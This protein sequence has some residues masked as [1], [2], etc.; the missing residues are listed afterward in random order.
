MNLTP[1]EITKLQ[2]YLQRKFANDDIQIRERAQAK[3]SAEVLINGEFIGVVYKDD[4]DSE[5]ISYD[6]NMSILNIDLESVA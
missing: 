5:D 3:D 1:Q 2:K 6:F 4:E